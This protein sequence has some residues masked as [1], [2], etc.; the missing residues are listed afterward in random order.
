[1]GPRDGRL[2]V[3]QLLG[4]HCHR[5]RLPHNRGPALGQAQGRQGQEGESEEGMID[6]SIDGSMDGG[7][8]LFSLFFG[9]GGAPRLVFWVWGV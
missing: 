4:P 6:R 9:G 8:S 3:G 5:R 2:A 1:M 7:L